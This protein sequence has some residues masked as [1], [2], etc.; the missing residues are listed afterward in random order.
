MATLK[1]TIPDDIAIILANDAKEKGMDKSALIT[2]ILKSYYG[3]SHAQSV[4][5]AFDVLKGKYE[6]K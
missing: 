4:L 6:F 1:A 2:T 5:F 3:D